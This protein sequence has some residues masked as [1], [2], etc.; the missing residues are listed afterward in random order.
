MKSTRSGIL[1]NLD[2]EATLTTVS[3]EVVLNPHPESSRTRVVAP[4]PSTAQWF[5]TMATCSGQG[6]SFLPTATHT[7]CTLPRIMVGLR[8]RGFPKLPGNYGSATTEKPQPKIP[9]H[10]LQDHF[11]LSLET[12]SP[13]AAVVVSN[14]SG[15]TDPFHF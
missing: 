5:L 7:D 4:Q 11:L 14:H 6:R 1:G 13:Q 15:K 10:D 9:A 8:T 2:L 3:V 12:S